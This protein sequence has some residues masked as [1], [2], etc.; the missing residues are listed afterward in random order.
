MGNQV[1][2]FQIIGKHAPSLRE[3]YEKAFDWKFNSVGGPADY[4]LVEN[5]GLSGGIG[6][7]P[8]GGPGHVTFFVAVDDLASALSKIES[9]GA[10]NLSGPWPIPNG[11]QMATFED[12]QGQTLGLVQQ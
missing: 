10:K 1:V 3:F 7:C 11:G 2:H 6:A 4:S 9:L 8:E 5:A 12:P